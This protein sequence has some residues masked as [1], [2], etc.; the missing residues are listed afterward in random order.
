MGSVRDFVFSSWNSSVSRGLAEI[1]SALDVSGLAALG[2]RL[3]NPRGNDLIVILAA[4]L[5]G[6]GHDL[7]TEDVRRLPVEMAE[8]VRAVAA[9]LNAAAP[10]ASG[11]P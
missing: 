7:D 11:R 1:E 3:A 5:R 2:E 9:A 4:L 10:E 6:G 8:A